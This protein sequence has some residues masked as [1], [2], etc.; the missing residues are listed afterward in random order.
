MNGPFQLSQLAQELSAQ[1]VGDDVSISRVSTDTRSVESGDLFI[2]LRGDNFDAHHFIQ[3]AADSGAVAVVVEHQVDSD[4]PQLI[5]S[6]TRQA[7]GQIAQYNRQYFNG[8]LFA[9]TGSSGKTTVKEMLAAINKQRGQTLAT[10]GNLNNDIGVPLTLLRLSEGDQYAVIE[11]GASGPHE[12]AYSTDLARPDVAILNNAMGAHLEGFGSLQ[13]VVQAKA[14]IFSGLSENGVA[15]VNLDDPHSSYWLGML[16]QQP[17]LTFSILDSAADV[18]ASDIQ[19]Q[20]NGCYQFKLNYGQESQLVELGVL[21]R[22]NVANAVAAAAAVIADGCDL[23]TLATGLAQCVAVKGR[24]RPAQ[25]N[26]QTLLIDDSYNANPGAVKI[27]INS[28]IELNGDSVLVLGDMAEL[29][30]DELEQHRDVGRYAAQKGV[31]K[32]YTCGRLSAETVEAYLQAGGKEAMNLGSREALVEL[33]SQLPAPSQGLQ[34]NILVKGS[35][36]AAMDQV[37]DGL[38]DGGIC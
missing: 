33:L 16:M 37:V 27:A 8:S 22:H 28:L 24:M 6:N 15:I 26:Q 36:S 3:Q 18:Y 17:V 4:L 20:N 35:R 14:E 38:T 11:M 7:L 34:R 21:G 25:L 12:I 29:G 31:N 13:G 1:L 32:L 2:A 10:I 23:G 30:S 9:I 5:V 19:L